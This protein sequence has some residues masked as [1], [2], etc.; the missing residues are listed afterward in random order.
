MV[1]VL[2]PAGTRG[3]GLAT[4][5]SWRRRG[6]GA[7]AH[8]RVRRPT[9]AYK[10]VACRHRTP[11]AEQAWLSELCFWSLHCSQ[12]AFKDDLFGVRVSR[13]PSGYGAMMMSTHAPDLSKLSAWPE[14]RY[15]LAVCE[16]LSGGDGPGGQPKCPNNR[17]M[18][19]T[20]LDKKCK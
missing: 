3:S 14:S 13:G 6:Q 17:S 20:K 7:A 10:L 11:G 19:E 15:R 9:V 18:K 1:L 12:V 4:L 8:E 16:A 5:G 2:V